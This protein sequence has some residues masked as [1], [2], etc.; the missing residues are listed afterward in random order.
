MGSGPREVGGER[1]QVV[2]RRRWVERTAAQAG[3]LVAHAGL[4]AADQ[5]SD[6]CDA[7]QQEQTGTRLESDWEYPPLTRPSNARPDL[8]EWQHHDQCEQAGSQ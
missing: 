8:W 1:P 4:T 3:A 7:V 5:E 6:S 2:W